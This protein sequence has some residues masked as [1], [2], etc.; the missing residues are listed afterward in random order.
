MI[1]TGEKI[2]AQEAWRLGAVDELVEPDRLMERALEIAKK[3]ASQPP[4]AVRFAKKAVNLSVESSLAAGLL[5]EQ[6]QSIY[7]LGSEDKNEAAAAFMEKRKPKYK[8]R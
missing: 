6:V 3:I 4:M 7:C 8:G 2:D 1:L 5:F